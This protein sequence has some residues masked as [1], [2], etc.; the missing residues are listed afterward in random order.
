MEEIARDHARR[1]V[2]KR[3]ITVLLALRA[4]CLDALNLIAEAPDDN[5]RVVSVAA[6]HIGHVNGLIFPIVAIL[7]PGHE[8]EPI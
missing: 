3:H 2:S 5:R 7:V 6:Y 8:P 4:G 1:V